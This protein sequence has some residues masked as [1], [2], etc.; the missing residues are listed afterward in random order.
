MFP[1]K[2][3]DTYIESTGKRSTIG[4]K[5]SEGGSSLPEHT[6]ADA[7]K[8]LKVGDDGDLEWD[9]PGTSVNYMSQSA[10]NALTFNEKKAA[11]FTA[12]G[13]AGSTSGTYYDYSQLMGTWRYNSD[14]DNIIDIYD[15]TDFNFHGFY[16][17]TAN[18]RVY[19]GAYG[20]ARD[21]NYRAFIC[22]Y[23]PAR[24][25]FLMFGKT[26][27]DIK[28]SNANAYSIRKVAGRDLYVG[29][30]FTQ[31]RDSA[32]TVK[33]THNNVDQNLDSLFDRSTTS[34][35]GGSFDSTEVVIPDSY[36]TI[37]NNIEDFLN[38]ST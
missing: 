34:I 13:A 22:T 11:G 33:F 28:C 14:V 29:G 17:V 35:I 10:W 19:C 32:T 1:I 21:Y 4:Q 37:L 23:A 30:I 8:V 36:A 27:N 15:G 25:G 18:D 24:F 38:S 12:I 5:I 16:S 9:E 26:A 2:S 20:G 7:G 31:L 3:S 6:E